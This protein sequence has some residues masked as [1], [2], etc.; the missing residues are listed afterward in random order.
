MYLV[1]HLVDAVTF[2]A[3]FPLPFVYKPVFLSTA[4]E[5]YV[6]HHKKNRRCTEGAWSQSRHLVHFIGWVLTALCLCFI[7]VLTY[8]L[9]LP[10]RP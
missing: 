5:A 7:P 10:L 3:F 1:M 6:L 4:S 8:L 2:T 9:P